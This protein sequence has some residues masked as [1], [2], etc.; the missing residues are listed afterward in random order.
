MGTSDLAEVILDSLIKSPHDIL[1]VVTQPDS[2]NKNKKVK[3]ISPVKKTAELKK[4]Q[5]LQPTKIDDQFIDDIE[6]LKPDLIVVAAYGKI[7]PEEVLNIPKFKSLNVHASLLPKLRGPSPIQNSLLNGEKE[8]GITIMKMDT[9]IDTGDIISQ[10]KLEIEPEDDY[11]TLTGKLAILGSHL[12]LDTIDKWV[13]GDI[14][15]VSQDSSQATLCQLIEKS[16][17]KIFWDKD[18]DYIHNAFR[19]FRV[20]PGVFTFWENNNSSKKIAL[21]DIHPGSN[22]ESE[23]YSL[24]EVFQREN[25]EVCIQASS[26][27]IIIEKLQ[28]EGKKEAEIKSFINGYPNFIGSILS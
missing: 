2:E 10:D 20:W 12:L 1:A 17:G 7:L 6:K 15:A 8:T 22:S 13:Q 27:V 23:S 25:G 5:L 11:V 28:L 3:I 24:G 9:G 19:A 14:Q 4:L 26:G 18:K 16:D 21:T